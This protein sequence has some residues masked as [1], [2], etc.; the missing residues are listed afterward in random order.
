MKWPFNKPPEGIGIPKLENLL[1][2]KNPRAAEYKELMEFAKKYP[3]SDVLEKLEIYGFTRVQIPDRS[4][5]NEEYSRN[6]ILVKN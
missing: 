5:F 4:Y 2:Y 3:Y 1:T 6:G